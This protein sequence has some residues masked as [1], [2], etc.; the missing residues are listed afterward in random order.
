MLKNAILP[1]YLRSEKLLMK[2]NAVLRESL[3]KGNSP[4]NRKIVNF[5]I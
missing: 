1:R 4:I 5:E 3:I 2:I